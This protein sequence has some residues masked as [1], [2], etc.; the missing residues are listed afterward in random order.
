[1]CNET[2]EKLTVSI[3][4]QQNVEKNSRDQYA[5]PTWFAF[6]AGR[7]TVS[8]FKAA[9]STNI[10]KP[11]VSLLVKQICYP[12]T[13]KFS[14]AA[15]RWGTDQETVARPGM[16]VNIQSCKHKSLHLQSCGFL[17]EL[18]TVLLMQHV[19]V[20]NSLLVW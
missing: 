6:R 9:V 19:M 7:I 11:S 3:Y 12:G 17:L 20:Y 13:M 5:S 16:C 1:M 4:Q 10:A 8:K 18:K 14:S 15:T 2:E